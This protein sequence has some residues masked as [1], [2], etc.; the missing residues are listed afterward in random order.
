MVALAVEGEVLGRRALRH[1][2]MRGKPVE[3]RQR[4]RG[5]RGLDR[6]ENDEPLERVA[7]G[8]PRRHALRRLFGRLAAQVC[9]D[10]ARELVPE[11]HMGRLFGRVL[12][13]LCPDRRLGRACRGLRSLGESHHRMA[14]LA[15]VMAELVAGQLP[16]APALVEGMLEDV[17]AALRIGETV[18]K[19]HLISFSKGSD[20]SI[21]GARILPA[22]LAV[23]MRRSAAWFLKGSDP[24]K[25]RR[26]RT[27]PGSE[28]YAPEFPPSLAWLNVAFLRMDK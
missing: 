7:G 28:L 9:V 25:L 3:L 13:D 17:A 26:V 16:S 21:G 12:L 22:R 24:F 2:V 5:L 11:I 15:G 4:D 18:E 14:V 1:S 19:R 20:P 23:F 10:C 27:P 8:R 6:V